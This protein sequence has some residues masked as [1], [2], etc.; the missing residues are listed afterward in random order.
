MTAHD[1]ARAVW[2]ERARGQPGILPGGKRA[3]DG[4]LRRKGG[5]PEELPHPLVRLGAQGILKACKPGKAVVVP[6][7]PTD[8]AFDVAHVEGMPAPDSG[9]SLDQVLI[10]TL[11]RITEGIDGPHSGDYRATFHFEHHILFGMPAQGESILA[12]REV[13]CVRFRSGFC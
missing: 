11:E 1:D 9:S 6:Q 3:E 7:V 4:D 12:A 2:V 13:G 10:K 5:G 8:L